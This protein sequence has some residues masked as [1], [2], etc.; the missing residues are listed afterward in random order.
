MTFEG[1]QADEPTMFRPPAPVGNGQFPDG[2]GAMNPQPLLGLTGED[3]LAL[4]PDSC[5]VQT[6]GQGSGRRRSQGY[7]EQRA[8]YRK[9][10]SL[11][12]RGVRHR[13]NAPYHRDRGS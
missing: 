5:V 7:Y 3:A 2:Q 11:L 10:R 9:D 1:W 13:D 12:R 8:G 4:R 6:V